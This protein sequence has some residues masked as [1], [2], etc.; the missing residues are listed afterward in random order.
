MG[1]KMREARGILKPGRVK[2]RCCTGS[3]A[4]RAPRLARWHRGCTRTSRIHGR[5]AMSQ[6]QAERVVGTIT[7]LSLA[8]VVVGVWLVTCIAG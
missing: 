3:A 6:A 7:E 5:A 2:L 8:L 1:R 4:D